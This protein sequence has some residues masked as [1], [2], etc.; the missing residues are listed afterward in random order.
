M[1]FAQPDDDQL[2]VEVIA[3]GEGLLIPMHATVTVHYNGTLEDGTLFDSSYTRGQPLKFKVGAGEVI[4]GW[5]LAVLQLK[6]RSKAKVTIPPS[7]AY[8]EEGLGDKVPP[9]AHL[10]F[11]VEVF[12]FELGSRSVS[13]PAP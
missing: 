4:R 8:G 1:S 5:D 10:I 13:E 2:R 7:L 6:K 9:N 11:V 3:E 12:G